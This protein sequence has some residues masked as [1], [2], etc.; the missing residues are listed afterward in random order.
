M[1]NSRLFTILTISIVLISMSLITYSRLSRAG[2]STRLNSIPGNLLINGDFD[3]LGFYSRPPNHLVGDTWY[4]WWGD[5]TNIPEYINGGH[6]FHN[7]CY[8][9]PPNTLCHNDDTQ[10]FNNSQGLI[11]YGYGSFLAGIYKPVENVYPCM[12][13]KFEI[14]N[15]NDADSYYYRPTI[16]IDPNGWIITQPSGNPIHNCPP[17]GQSE[18]PD[19]YVDLDTGFP[20]TMIWSDPIG[21]PAYTWAKGSLTV[22]ALNTTISV[23][24]YTYPDESQISKSSY[25]DY[26][27]VVHV[28]FPDDKLPVPASWSPSGVIYS[29]NTTY[30][31]SDVVI[32]WNT[33]FPASTQV[34]YD[35]RPDIEPG[36]TQGLTNYVYLPSFQ[37]SMYDITDPTTYRF[38]T[39]IQPDLSTSHQVTIS[40]LN[41]GDSLYFVPLSKYVQT[42]MCVTAS[43]APQHI[44]INLP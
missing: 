28:P 2:D 32:T 14:W 4:E 39:P 19:P 30:Q 31:G 24:T 20:V 29:L 10:T 33:V 17:D 22:E 37:G 21:Q 25:W 36:S 9:N 18:C 26:G 7:Q 35:T 43:E 13:Y 38:T 40:G 41:D 6:P 15:R 5:Y 42:N 44:T 12:L 1:K 16:G 8:P 27:S 3:Q 11:R 23:W 34:W